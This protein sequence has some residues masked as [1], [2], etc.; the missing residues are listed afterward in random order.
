MT[1]LNI[2]GIEVK[3]K[4]LFKIL[5]QICEILYF[6]LK[7]TIYRFF[8]ILMSKKCVNYKIINPNTNNKPNYHIVPSIV[9]MYN[10]NATSG[11]IYD[12]IS[13]IYIRL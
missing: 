1:K 5:K 11:Q 9:I 4:K 12:L 7:T 2:T 3:H 6:D 13:Y 10:S 8:F